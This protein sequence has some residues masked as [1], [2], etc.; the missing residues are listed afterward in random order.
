MDYQNL[1]YEKSEGIGI[2]TLNRP[3]AL[4]ALNTETYSELYEVFKEIEN[5]ASVRVVILTGS[6]EKAF[7]AGTDIA[8]MVSLT[9]EEALKFAH[10][11]RKACEAI[12]YLKKPVIAAINGYALGGG[13][14][15]TLCADFRIASETAK[16]GQPEINLA[17]IPGS[18]GTQ[19]LSRLIG[20]SRAKELV[21]FGNIIDAGT[22][23]SWGLV[24]KVVPAG[25]L[26]EET[27]SLAK[28]L[29]AKSSPI[30]AL[31]KRAMN[32]GM[33]ADLSQGLDIE[34]QS[35]SECFATE[36]QKEGMR[37]FLDKRKPDF[38]NK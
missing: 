22:A 36:D 19:R 16:F 31:A 35:F 27:R 9:P 37:A 11:L 23:L 18:G 29:L 30:L 5:D 24:N 17:I 1:L 2:V 13:C 15:L 20:L 12:Y 33:E 14:E 28:G 6:G 4:N 21:Y 38:K 10:H 8:S 34:A 25:K 32:Q 3:Q 26:V 7:A